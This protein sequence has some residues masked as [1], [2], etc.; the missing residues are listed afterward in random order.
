[1]IAP[2]SSSQQL[3]YI[4]AGDPYAPKL[5][6][7]HAFPLSSEMWRPQIEEF[8][9]QFDCIAPDFRGI[10]ESTPF[11]TRPSFT[12]IADDV[13]LLLN[14]LHIF[15]QVT[16]CGLSM[17]GYCAF[18]FVRSFPDRVGKLILCDTRPDADS[19]QA[20]KT[21][22]ELLEFA[23]RN[24]ASAVAEKMLPKLLGGTTRNEKPDVVGRVKE[25]AAPHRTEHLAAMIQALRD[26]R[27]STELLPNIK[28]PTLV[29]SGEEDE[30]S[31][32][33][34]MRDMA[35]H[36]PNAKFV[37]I[38]KAGHLSNLENTPD[39]NAALREFVGK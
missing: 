19:E 30:I 25:L 16:L 37:E 11:E 21:R 26:R 24:N 5:V 34:L 35:L 10:G 32:P 31:T 12:M 39:F 14:H 3:S 18:E 23:L 15:Q 28:V 36:I 8:S 4:R 1:M 6:F 7:L 22:N 17:G 27:D 9:S 38:E 2:I 13:R 33:E 29:I 20:R